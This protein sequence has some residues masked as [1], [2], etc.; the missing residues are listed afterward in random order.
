MEKP[1]QEPE[2]KALCS[3]PGHMLP[4]FIITKATGMGFGTFPGETPW[5]PME[6]F[7]LSSACTLCAIVATHACRRDNEGCACCRKDWHMEAWQKFGSFISRNMIVI[8]PLCLVAGIFFPAFFQRF[9]PYVS[10]MFAVITFQG[11]LSNDFGNLKRTF[12]HPLPMILAI[13]ISQLLMPVLGWLLGHLFFTD[14]DL[15]CGIVLE[16][17]VPIAVTSTM[18]VSLYEGNMSLTLGTLLI[19]TCMAPFTIPATLQL[20]MGAT[21]EVDAAGMILDML[22]MIAIPALLG[23]ALNDRTK[24]RAKQQIS[25]VLA[26]LARILTILVITTNS[27]SLSTFIFNLTPEL[28]GVLVLIGF[29]A[30]SGYVW[31]FLAARLMHLKRADAVGMT[32]LCAMKNIS[33]GAIIAQ[34]YFPAITLFPVMTGTLFNQFFA[35]LFGKLFG[36]TFRSMQAEEARQAL[37]GKRAQDS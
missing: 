28:A 30:S 17:T 9:A 19:S 37:V 20:L 32:F 5:G 29:L 8:V 15:I 16:Y 11:S 22:F 23:T 27:T 25:P 12:S 33:A 34:E 36:R 13:L 24:G 1:L 6:P 31:G 26:P 14:T 3:G 10:P 18:W 7:C 4:C 35:A 2:T 21:V